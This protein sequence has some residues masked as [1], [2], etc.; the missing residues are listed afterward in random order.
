MVLGDENLLFYVNLAGEV[1][2]IVVHRMKS[3]SIRTDL[4]KRVFDDLILVICNP[5]MLQ[6]LLNGTIKLIPN[7]S[8]TE[9]K[10]MLSQIVHSSI[11]NI[12]DYSMEKVSN[13]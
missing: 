9:L 8:L 2:Y 5:Q 3:Q 11:M 6:D 13:K 12:N 7:Y 4:Q 10:M 1:F